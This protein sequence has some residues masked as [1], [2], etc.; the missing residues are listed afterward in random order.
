MNLSRCIQYLTV[1]CALFPVLLEQ[2]AAN[3]FLADSANL[4]P[5]RIQISLLEH[6]KG[7]SYSVTHSRLCL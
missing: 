5:Q 6:V 7:R 3:L 2:D 4:S 1:H